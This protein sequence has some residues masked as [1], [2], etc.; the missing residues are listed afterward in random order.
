MIRRQPAR[1]AEEEEEI[2]AAIAV[3]LAHFQ[4]FGYWPEQSGGHPG[5]IALGLGEPDSGRT[6]RYARDPPHR[7]RK[8]RA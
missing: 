3:A 8:D 6:N 5:S 1:E 7:H 2:A 4:G